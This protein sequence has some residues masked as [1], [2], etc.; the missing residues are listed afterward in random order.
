VHVCGWD[1]SSV[2]YIDHLTHNTQ[3]R[4]TAPAPKAPPPRPPP[5]HGRHESDDEGK[6]EETTL[7]RASMAALR[8][9]AGQAP[10][11][12]AAVM[13]RAGA[14][15]AAEEEVGGRVRGCCSC[16]VCSVWRNLT[17]ESRLPYHTTKRTTGVATIALPWGSGPGVRH[18]GPLLRGRGAGAVRVGCCWSVEAGLL[19]GISGG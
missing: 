19:L 10:V 16:C 18:D 7:F 13:L 14:A 8:V 11:A 2:N 9:E 6:E 12:A 15:A 1:Q 3:A 4:T 17:N 5:P